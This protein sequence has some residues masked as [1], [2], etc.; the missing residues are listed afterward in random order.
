M[1]RLLNKSL[2]ATAG[3]ALAALAPQARAQLAFNTFVSD[4][5]LTSVYGSPYPIGFTFAGNKFVGS[6]GYDHGSNIL[7]QS[8]LT[9]TSVTAFGTLPYV[10]GEA[11]LSASPNG[12]SFGSNNIFAGSGANN[13]IWEI[14]NAGGAATLFSDGST[15]GISGTIRQISFDTSGLYS[16]DMIVTTTSGG[17]YKVD[18]TGN[19]SL[20]ASIGADTEGIGFATQQFGTY[21]AGTLFVAS[22]GLGGIFAVTPSGGLSSVASLSGVESL[23]F[24]PAGIASETNPLEGFY[25]VDYPYGVQFAG[26]SQFVPYA[27]DLIV[28]S[29]NGGYGSIYALSLDGSNTPTLVSIGSL[30][31]PEDSIFVTQGTLQTHSVPDQ[32]TTASM[33]A[34]SIVALGVLGLRSRRLAA[35]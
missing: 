16:N 8:D 29:E 30:N 2:V 35:S 20:L 15:N 5:Q 23:S 12:S 18:D 27:G 24:V 21:A 34:A 14:P 3:I 28:G 25:G 19:S 17:I 10:A 9:G 1:K 31:Q 11:V 33:L 22:E 32:G 13:N 7:Y 26:A 6:A 4:P